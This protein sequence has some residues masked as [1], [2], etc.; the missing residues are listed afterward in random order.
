[1]VLILMTI[2]VVQERCI[3]LKM[4]HCMAEIPHQLHFIMMQLPKLCG[5]ITCRSVMI[6]LREARR[7]LMNTWMGVIS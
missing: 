1:M 3:L 6:E 7:L 4:N 2:F 5:T